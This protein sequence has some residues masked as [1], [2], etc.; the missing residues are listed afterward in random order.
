MPTIK[1]NFVL[2]KMNL[3]VDDRLLQKG[4]YRTA[5]NIRIANSNGSD[6]GAIEKSL[7]NDKLTNLDLGENIFTIGGI[8]DEFKE[9]L[10][11]F[12]KSDSG[13]YIIE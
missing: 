5:S 9:K 12:V 13:S 1:N 10:Y 8:S 6:V 4:E 7:S 11:C 3:D 2:G